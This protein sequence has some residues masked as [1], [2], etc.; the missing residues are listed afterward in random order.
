MRSLAV[1]IICVS[2]TLSLLRSG[3]I[4]WRLVSQEELDAMVTQAQT[5]AAAARDNAAPSNRPFF[6]T[7][8]YH[9]AL[10]KGR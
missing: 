4:P 7:P 6:T 2:A 9:T 3:A 1:S 5:V 8:G 10:E